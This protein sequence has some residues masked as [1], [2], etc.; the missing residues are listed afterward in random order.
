MHEGDALVTGGNRGIGL[1]TARLLAAGGYRVWLGCRDLDR[2]LAAAA[3]IAGPGEA[4]AVLLDLDRPETALCAAEE[5]ARHA[6]ALDVL[7][8]NG[9]I[10]WGV[11]SLPETTVEELRATFSTNLF[12]AILTTQAMLPLLER[13]RCPRIV[14]LSSRQG[15]L[16][17]NAEEKVSFTGLAYPASKAALNMATIHMARHFGERAK[18]NACCPGFVAT[19]LHGRPSDRTPAHAAR[20]VHHLAMLDESGP[21]G[22]FFDESGP[23]PW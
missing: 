5:I 17:Y 2:G 14:N 15:S 21:S 10:F 8:N 1:A 23:I 9:G 22:C 6:D 16:A 7:I 3:A 4:R 11:S 20:I 12:G 13:A 18:V 19:D